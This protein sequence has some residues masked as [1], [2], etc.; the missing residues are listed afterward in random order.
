MIQHHPDPPQAKPLVEAR[1][2]AVP[3]GPPEVRSGAPSVWPSPCTCRGEGPRGNPWRRRQGEATFSLTSKS[4]ADEH[5]PA[6]A[7][8]SSLVVGDH[9]RLP[10]RLRQLVVKVSLGPGIVAG[11]DA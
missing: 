8:L 2:S 11:T 9:Q 3:S 4:R 5:A 1:A 6:G 7:I 10:L